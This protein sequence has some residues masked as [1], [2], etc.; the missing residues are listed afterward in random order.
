MEPRWTLPS[1]MERNPMAWYVTING[2]IVD[3]RGLP[4]PLQEEAYRKG[5]IPYLPSEKDNE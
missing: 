1:R 3:A 4:R 5:L 2:F